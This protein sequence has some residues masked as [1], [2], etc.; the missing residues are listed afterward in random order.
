MES[1]K[2]HDRPKVLKMDEASFIEKSARIAMA[3]A[4]VYRSDLEDKGE[5]P[6]SVIDELVETRQNEVVAEMA[7]DYVSEGTEVSAE[8]ASENSGKCLFG[9]GRREIRETNENVRERLEQCGVQKIELDGVLEKYQDL[10]ARNM[11]DMCES[12]PELQGYIG[13]IR[14]TELKEGVFACAGPVMGENGYCAEILINKEA[15]S[16]DGLERRIARLETPNWKG[17]TWLAG[18]GEDAVM[19]H[20][21]AHVLHLRLLAEEQGLA[22]GS[23]DKKAYREVQDMYNRNHIATEICYETMK[24]Q[25]IHPNEWAG[26]ISIYGAHDMGECFAEAI[27]EYETREHPREFATEVYNKY[28]RRLQENDDYTA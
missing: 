21:M 15:F 11:E 24:E 12:Y 27:S 2:C 25:G 8:Y 23:Y 9:F 13:S 10:V 1:G 28:Q 26:H 14:A 20:E 22:I 7:R 3:A 16:H 5:Y 17:E 18:Q 6:Q 4:D 19:K